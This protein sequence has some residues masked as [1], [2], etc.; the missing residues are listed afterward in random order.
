M[1]LRLGKWCGLVLTTLAALTI[2]ATPTAA[3]EPDAAALY[4]QH[5]R[6]CHGGKGV[7]SQSMLTVYPGLKALAD[8]G[9]FAK[10]PADS[11]VA[12]MQHGRG[13][14]MKS[15]SSVLTSE[16]MTAIAKYVK[17]L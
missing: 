16:Q 12:A 13:G 15:F 6:T 17:T 14:Q 1:S 9:A 8:S 4:R 5:C 10:L 7:P 2:G 3:Q 11:I